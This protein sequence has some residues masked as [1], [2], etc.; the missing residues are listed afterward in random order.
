LQRSEI[1][2][3]FIFIARSGFFCPSVTA[4]A[5]S[6]KSI[7]E[8]DSVELFVFLFLLLKSSKQMVFVKWS[9]QITYAKLVYLL[10][11][12]GG[13][14]ELC[15]NSHGSTSISAAPSIIQGVSTESGK[16]VR[17]LGRR[18][19]CKTTTIELLHIVQND[20]AA[21]LCRAVAGQ[22]DGRAE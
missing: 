22:E 18:V 12:A 11:L 20:C 16:R 19:A 21:V 2:F 8:V 9:K 17:G 6:S 10:D 7:I 15:A 14:R 13:I 1:L 4:I 5:E 3:A